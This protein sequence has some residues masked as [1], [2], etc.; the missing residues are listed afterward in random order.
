MMT[1]TDGNLPWQIIFGFQPSM[2]TTTIVQGEVLMKDRKLQTLDEEEISARALE[3]AP[4]VWK[5]Y[6]EEVAKIS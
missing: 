1:L 6:E 4:D 5:R 2:I 3:I